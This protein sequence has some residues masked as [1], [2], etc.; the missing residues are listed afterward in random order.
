MVM[1]SHRFQP[2]LPL[3]ASL[4]TALMLSST[5]MH[6]ASAQTSP[7]Q[8]PAAAPAAP[9]QELLKAEELEQLVAPIALY[10]D[11]LLASC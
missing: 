7:Q 4:L 8:A 2:A 1:N 11:T 9:A 5:A 3:A 10:P 6:D